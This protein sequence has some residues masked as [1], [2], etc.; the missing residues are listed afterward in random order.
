M[1]KTDR[2]LVWGNVRLAVWLVLVL[3]AGTLLGTSLSFA[4]GQVVNVSYSRGVRNLDPAHM[5][6][7]PDFPMGMNIFNGLVRYQANSTQ[8]EPDLAESWTVSDDAMVYTFK[9]REDVIWHRGYGTLTSADVKFSFERIRD[10]P[11]SRHSASLAN[12]AAID[13]PDEYTVQITLERPN[14]SFLTA[15]LPDRFGFI[16]PQAAVEDLGE[17]F[18]RLPVG[19]GPYVVVSNEPR[20]ALVLEANEQ[21]FRGR[22]AIDRIEWRAIEDEVVAALALQRG[23]IDYMIVRQPDAF[24]TLRDASGVCVNATPALG[25]SSLVFNLEREAVADLQVRRAVAHAINRPLMAETLG[26]GM[27]RAESFSVIPPG[28]FGH[29]DD[30]LDYAF[31][32]DAARQLL[33]EAGTPNP[34]VS[35]IFRRNVADAATAIERFLTE[36]GFQVTAELLEDGVYQSRRVEGDFDMLLTEPTNFEPDQMLE[37]FDSSHIPPQGSNESRYRGVDELIQRQKTE[38]DPQQRAQTLEEIQRRIAEDVPILVL[39]NPVYVTAYQ[40]DIEGH[41]AHTG[42]WMT[43]FEFMNIAR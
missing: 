32:P 25:W 13:T 9:L 39:W 4:Q 8:I 31:D 26:E 28:M 23:E 20:E 1:T 14:A 6:G 35:L 29:T 36:V 2:I 12:V 18:S 19:S 3:L 5:P 22:P 16:V 27:A 21:Y 34:S 40:C 10:D 37:L 24:R 33:A 41:E 38:L 15:T 42:F 17:D 43:R 7:V 11:G 30:I